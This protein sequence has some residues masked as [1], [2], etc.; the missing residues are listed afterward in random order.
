MPRGHL[1]MRGT[2]SP[3]LSDNQIAS[4]AVRRLSW[5]AAVPK[6]TVKVKVVHGRVTLRGVLQNAH[7]KTA[8]LE[9]VS[10]LFGVASISDRTRIKSTWR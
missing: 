10:R 5:D 3:R 2:G 9:D 1:A 6:D 7:Q 8:A 4:E